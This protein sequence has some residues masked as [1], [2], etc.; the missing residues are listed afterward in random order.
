MLK[1]CLSPGLHLLGITSVTQETCS[2]LV[3]IAT[4]G[5]SSNIAGNGL[6]GLVEEKL[7]WVIWMWCLAHK[8]ELA[9]NNALSSTSCFKLIDDMLLRLYYLYQKPSKKCRELANIISDLT[10]VYEINDQGELGQFELVAHVG[11]ATKSVQ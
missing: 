3:G 10:E 7:P 2:G 5:T 4:D 9:I 6:R 8:A 1:V 11:Y